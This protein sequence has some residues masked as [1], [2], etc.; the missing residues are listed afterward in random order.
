MENAYARIFARVRRNI[1][2]APSTPNSSTHRLLHLVLLKSSFRHT[3]HP[4]SSTWRSPHVP[5]FRLNLASAVNPS[6]SD[7]VR[8]ILFHLLTRFLLIYYSHQ[9]G[10]ARW[11]AKFGYYIYRN[12]FDFF[13]GFCIFLCLNVT[14]Y[15][16]EICRKFLPADCVRGGDTVL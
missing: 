11:S 3:F 10:K 6:L 5:S 8:F 9:V 2:Y 4:S 7:R 15:F 13:W 14:F 12:D 16:M 1:R